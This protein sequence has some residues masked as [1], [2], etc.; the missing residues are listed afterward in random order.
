MCF[1]RRYINGKQTHEKY[2]SHRETQ[3]KATV[4]ICF[5]LTRMTLKKGKEIN[6]AKDGD[7]EK[8]EFPYIVGSNVKWCSYCGK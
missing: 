2:V 6:V 1:Q 7:A 3:T 5:I 8:M 4:R